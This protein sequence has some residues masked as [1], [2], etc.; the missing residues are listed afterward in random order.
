MSVF[1]NSTFPPP[2]KLH[3]PSD[4]QHFS[5]LFRQFFPSQSKCFRS[6]EASCMSLSMSRSSSIS[7]NLMKSK[8]IFVIIPDDSQFAIEVEK[9]IYLVTFWIKYS[10]KF[11][12]CFRM[13]VRCLILFV[14]G[15]EFCVRN[16]E[17]NAVIYIFV[18]RGIKSRDKVLASSN[19]IK[20]AR[21]PLF[22][23]CYRRAKVFWV[24][25]FFGDMR[26]LHNES[27]EK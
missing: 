1:I 19:Y 18:I 27:I 22:Y 5:D 11:S 20:F 9:E 12:Y 13:C 15:M 26:K 21:N 7:S 16:I 4:Y 25:N 3:F 23:D 17:E 6:S 24:K 10:K 8:I 2:T 14:H